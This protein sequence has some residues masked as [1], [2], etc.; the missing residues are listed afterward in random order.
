MMFTLVSSSSNAMSPL[1]PLI[2]NSICSYQQL[3]NH[4][5]SR[6][7]QVAPEPQVGEHC[8]KVTAAVQ[9]FLLNIASVLTVSISKPIIFQK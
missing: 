7:R 6:E 3:G 4:M 2:S 5:K 9:V 1:V 8:H